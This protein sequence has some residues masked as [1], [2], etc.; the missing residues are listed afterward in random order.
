MI[1]AIRYANPRGMW[2]EYGGIW[3]DMERYDSQL[4]AWCNFQALATCR[5]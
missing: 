4:I 2:G 5:V 1:A 3:R